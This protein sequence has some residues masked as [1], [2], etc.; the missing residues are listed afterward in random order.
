M[1]THEV[2]QFEAAAAG[3]ILGGIL[4]F[5]AWCL[6]ISKQLAKSE[7]HINGFGESKR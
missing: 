4:M 7:A 1:T 3:G 2:H 6:V 5:L